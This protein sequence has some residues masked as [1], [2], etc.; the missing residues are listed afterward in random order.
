MGLTKVTPLRLL[1]YVG[2]LLLLVLILVAGPAKMLR[3]ALQTQPLWLLLAFVL[4]LPQLGLKALRWF[5][6]VR[7]QGLRLSY[8]RA[9]LAYFGCLLVGFLTP[10]RLGEVTKAFT[11]KYES[12]TSLSHALSSVVLDRAFDMYLLLTLGSLGIVR[13]AVLGAVFPWGTFLGI[14]VLF[15]IP[16][17]FLHQR[18]TRWAGGRL[19]ALP[20]LR[21]WADLLNEKVNRFADGL[22]VLSPARILIAVGLTICSYSIF[23]FQCLCCAWA[24]NFNVLFTDLVML[25]A[26]S[27]F[28][29]FL[30]VTVSG[31]GTREACLTYFLARVVPPQP[32]AVAVTF[33]LALFLVLFVGG[34]LI[35][36]ACWQWAPIGLRQAV[37]DFRRCTPEEE[38]TE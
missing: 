36:F 4:N 20:L 27:N 2:V 9:L 18:V 31:L 35:G 33:G 11:L 16:L 14:C 26:A 32:Q 3:V 5:L 24:L 25:M 28:I 1:R 17:L 7:W 13:F 38:P 15:A 34:G 23:F 37:R 22:A 30:P 12:G 8:P 6:L 19:T 29:S 21:T 10:G